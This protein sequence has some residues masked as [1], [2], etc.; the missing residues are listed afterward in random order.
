V[1]EPKLR[2]LTKQPQGRLYERKVQCYLHLLVLNLDLREWI[3]SRP[4]SQ[5]NVRQ[6]VETVTAPRWF[7][8]FS[9][10]QLILEIGANHFRLG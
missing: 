4:A 6:P 9:L 1:L 5:R 2:F 3:P 10:Y 8:T 7:V